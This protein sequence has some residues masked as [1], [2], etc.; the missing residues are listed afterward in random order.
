MDLLS[1][2]RRAFGKTASPATNDRAE[3]PRAEPLGDAEAG[4]F[5]ADQALTRGSEDRLGRLPFALRIA[6][7]IR[8]RKAADSLVIGVYGP[9]GDGKTSVVQFVQE[10]LSSDD[11]IVWVPFNPWIV[12]DRD[13]LLRSFFETI[14]EALDTHLDSRGVTLARRVRDYSE[15][16]AAVVPPA[17]AV[18]LA[19]AAVSTRKLADY[20]KVVSDLLAD[21]GKRVVVAIDDIDRL[22]RN[23]IA[24]I[25]KLVRLVA[26]FKN[27][28][29]ILAFDR[30]I[31]AASLDHLY[32]GGNEEGSSFLEKIVQVPLPLPP[33]ESSSLEGF[34]LTLLE[35]ALGAAHVQLEASAVTEFGGRF[36]AGIAPGISTPRN[37]VQFVNAVAFA[38]PMLREEANVV[39]VICIEALRSLYPA[40]HAF[41]RDNEQFVLGRGHADTDG[42]E[43][44]RASWNAATLPLSERKRVAAL[45]L[46]KALFP[47][48]ESSLGGNTHY[49]GDWNRTWARE[50]RAA[51]PNHFERFFTYHVSAHQVSE[52]AVADL[53]DQITGQSDDELRGA[54]LE[55]IQNG[56]AESLIEALR[57]REGG[58][59]A[60]DARRLALSLA[61][62]GTH[63]PRPSMLF[64]FR[65]PFEQAAILISRLV[66]RIPTGP[67]R[68][69]LA[70]EVTARATPLGFAAHIVR[71]IRS[72]PDTQ[73]T[74]RILTEHGD[75]RILEELVARMSVEAQ[76][77]DPLYE[78]YP[79]D[80]AL[81][82]NVWAMYGPVGACQE[83]VAR[84]LEEHPERAITLL[85]AFLPTSYAMDTGASR[86]SDLEREQ[87]DSVIRVIDPVNLVNAVN[88]AYPDVAEPGEYPR[89]FDEFSDR[90]LAAQ[91]L[92]VHSRRHAPQGNDDPALRVE[93]DVSPSVAVTRDQDP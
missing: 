41:V 84:T 17:K 49:G 81:L 3:Q 29:Y 10:A 33:A 22:E 39:D 20:K 27:T 92:F 76:T 77:G 64:S 12:G 42:P 86:L 38:L 35:E 72:G 78:R 55:H 46:V 2:L 59:P 60:D 11:D 30:R 34:A 8:E 85:M 54:L 74:E 24:A 91:F 40:V 52:T 23:E 80:A 37:A 67:E 44:A 32:A 1:S 6:A 73:E 16:L 4:E 75:R 57:E 48:F 79:Q 90:T 63:L 31:V 70:L 68:S 71:W 87:Y 47:R 9:W 13:Q 69:Q 89:S 7:T 66:E 61:G 15:I 65:T 82:L 14:A 45:T 50:K 83:Y 28:V 43:P 93:T 51:S 62:L 53:V 88:R 26:D 18:Q 25:L 19:S 5:R 58:V 21:S 36:R 56:R